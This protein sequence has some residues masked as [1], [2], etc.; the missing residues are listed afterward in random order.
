MKNR[1]PFL[2][3]FE[4]KEKKLVE[5]LAEMETRHQNEIIVDSLYLYD[6]A[7]RMNKGKDIAHYIS[8]RAKKE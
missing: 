3:R 2:I 4:K 1:I 6:Y 7:V 5:D 8:K